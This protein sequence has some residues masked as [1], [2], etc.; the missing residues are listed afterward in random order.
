MKLLAKIIIIAAVFF[1]GFYFGQQ[2]ALS[3]S[4]GN[5]PVAEENNVTEKNHTTQVQDQTVKTEISVSLMLV[6]GNSQV[7]TYNDI[8]MPLDFYG[9]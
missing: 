8:T 3:P 9:L 4:A 5:Q 6:F 7:R 1:G 2:Q